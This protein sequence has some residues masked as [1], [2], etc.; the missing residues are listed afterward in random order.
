ML[1]KAG[2]YQTDIHN[3]AYMDDYCE[4]RL[5]SGALINITGRET[6]SLNGRWNF[7]ADWYDTCRRAKWFKEIRISHE[8][9]LQPLDWD[10]E[11]WD[12]I[13]VPSTWNTE[14]RELYYYEGSGIYTRTFRYIKRQNDERVFLRFEGAA[15]RTTVF[16]NKKFIGVHDGASTPFNVD[17]SDTVETENRLVLAVDARRSPLRIPMDNTDWFSYGGIYRDVLLVRTPKLF[18]KDWFIRLVPDGSFSRILA[19][20][21]I[22]G[23]DDSAESG[24]VRL[25]IEELNIDLELPVKNGK[26]GTEISIKAGEL[27]LASGKPETLRCED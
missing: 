5:E 24:K 6:E 12:R 4:P 25:E 3:A 18:L 19:D 20:V 1:N 7:A 16:L 17:I 21:T 27:G 13:K 8:G 26:A 9:E 14:M 15:Y 23:G 10:W 22:A 2:N 11:A